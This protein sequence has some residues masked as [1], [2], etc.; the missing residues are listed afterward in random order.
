MTNDRAKELIEE[1]WG[2][3]MITTSGIPGE[4]YTTN[5]EQDIKDLAKEILSQRILP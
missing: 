4:F 2:K 1:R 5:R 3:T